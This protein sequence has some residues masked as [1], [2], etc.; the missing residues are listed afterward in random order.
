MKIAE[1]KR[2]YLMLFL[3]GGL[4]SACSDDAEKAWS[5][6]AEAHNNERIIANT[7]ATDVRLVEQAKDG[8]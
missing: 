3:V 1:M 7:A 5:L 6:P 4:L 8:N 2:N